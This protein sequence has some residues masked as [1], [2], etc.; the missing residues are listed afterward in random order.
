MCSPR[1]ALLLI[2]S[3]A[4][5]LLYLPQSLL[6]VTP[7]EVQS[8]EEQGLKAF[9][10]FYPIDINRTVPCPIRGLP[11]QHA[12]SESQDLYRRSRRHLSLSLTHS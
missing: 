11:H 7:P 5:A 3:V 9:A 8:G 10:A 2:S 6:S 12:C 4:I 1:C